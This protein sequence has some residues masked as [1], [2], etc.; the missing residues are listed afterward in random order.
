MILYRFLLFLDGNIS[1]LHLDDLPKI[2]VDQTVLVLDNINVEKYFKRCLIRRV[3]LE[4]KIKYHDHPTLYHCQNSSKFISKH[5]LIDMEIDCA[6]EDDENYPGSCSLND[7]YRVKCKNQNKCRSPLL[8]GDA[9]DGDVDMN[10]MDL[11]FKY[12]CNGIDN[13]SPYIDPHTN[14]SIDET[15]C[16]RHI[17][18]CDNMYTRCDGFWTCKDGQDESNCNQS[19]CPNGTHPCVSPLNYTVCCLSEHRIGD[20]INDCLGASDEPLLCRLAYPYS[21]N[22]RRFECVETHE[23]LNS[24]K[25]CDGIADCLHGDDENFCGEHRLV[26]GKDW[27]VNRTIVEHLLCE[28]SEKEQTRDT[29]YI[30]LYFIRFSNTYG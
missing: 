18:P 2:F 6:Y 3:D 1:C 5:R 30:D 10:P 21:Q 22:P 27:Y 25:L 12:L 15:Q 28:L 17:W 14:L 29:I 20:N 11:L 4:H 8:F 19:L 13:T 9:C 26:C 23:C 24:L 7:P 16:H